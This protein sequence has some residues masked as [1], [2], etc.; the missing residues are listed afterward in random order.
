V[1]LRFPLQSFLL[2]VVLTTAAVEQ[3]TDG[4]ISGLV[5]DPTGGAI[6]GAEVLIVNDATGVKYVGAANGEGIYAVPNLPP[7]TYRIQVSKFGFK[8]LIKPDVVLSVQAA[9][10]INFTLPI[11]AVSETVTVQGGVTMV[12]ME[13]ASVST[14]IDRS[15]VE[16]MPLNG[17]SFQ[18]LI[19][20]TPGIVTNNPQNTP[21]ATGLGISGEFSVNG[22]RSESNYYIVDGVGANV[23]IYPGNVNE[24][25]TGGSL[26]AATALGTTQGL[27]SVDALQEF[28]VQSSTYSA[29]YGRS[30]GGQF[31]FVTRSGTNRWHGTAFDFLRNDLFDANDWFNGYYGKAKPSLRQN[32]FGGTVGGPVIVPGVYN[33]RNHTFFF[34]SY[35]GLR[36]DQPQAATLNYVPDAALRQSAPPALQ[37]V[38]NAFPVANGADVG[39]GLAEFT[40]TWSNPSQ[41]DATS[42]RFD[43]SVSDRLRLFFRF[44]STS[45]SAENRGTSDFSTPS[46][47]QSTAF[48]NH[49]YTLGATDLI[50]SRLSNDFRLNYSSNDSSTA[51]RI[52]SFG[53]GQAV[54]LTQLQ[55]LDQA[56]NPAY[57]VSV[58]L[59]FAGFGTA[60]NQ[61]RASGKQRQWNLVDSVNVTM[62]RHQFK[63]GADYRRL[64]PIQLSESPFALYY[65]FSAASAEANTI[66]FGLGETFAP[67]FPVYKNF[68]AFLQD[69]WRLSPKLTVSTGLRW[70][71]NPAPGAAKSGNL[72]YAT[73]GSS[74]SELSLASHGAPLWRTSWFNFAPRLGAAYVVRNAVGWET[75][76]RGGT[77]VFF[78]T[79]QQNAGAAWFNPGFS[80]T[81]FFSG[82]FPA[83]LEQVAPAIINPP[84]PPYETT[85][86]F[87]THFQLPYTL[88]W[89]VAVEQA[90]GRSQA[91][92]MSYVGA[93]GRRLLART[94]RH[95]APGHPNCTYVNFISNSLT[96]D[97]DALQLQFQRRLSG[98]LQALASYTWSHSIDSNSQNQSYGP[99]F[100]GNSDFDIRNN[101]SAALSYELPVTFRSPL[102]RAVLQHWG[103]DSRISARTGFP[104]TLFGNAF[105]DPTGQ[106]VYQGLN[107]VASHPVYLYGD[108]FPGGRSINPA[109]FMPVA[110]G[111]VGNAP[112]NFVNG[113]GAW[114][115]DVAIR[116]EFSIF[117]ALKLQLRVEAFNLFNHPNL[118]SIDSTYCAPGPGCRFGQATA[119][120]A[121]SLGVL[122]PLYQMGGSRSMQFALKL[123]F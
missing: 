54:D 41:I 120:L 85:Y 70:D 15:Y 49:T 14:V 2:L 78:D 37:P 123:M 69:E 55:G 94:E 26:P 9:V 117:E 28:R 97:Y 24:P 90:F 87:P 4:T 62:G 81:N 74:D 106:Y 59:S 36:L 52:T 30:P 86:A 32:D 83:P 107:M 79:G 68:S 17:R 108:Q 39:N 8:S 98:G 10:A 113:F 33:G 77:G 51:E 3:S 65:Y 66:D 82:T 19:L 38:L 100:R 44:A 101:L 114:Q 60:I 92:T 25:S 76:V 67:A 40:G 27:V 89:N 102:V 45:S 99:Y 43:Q 47:V 53:G 6:A 50:S 80:A 35:E 16:N 7:G 42:V 111:A 5:L 63:F 34:F 109:A 118:G 116:R 29:E 122:S 96:S 1:R 104:V 31:S 75:V 12:N 73:Q 20:L 23:G 22:Q 72:P 48:A 64:T 21:N 71:V 13:S 58:D 105:F 93:A 61:L 46:N 119:T 84:V 11:G 95:I 110:S 112:R 56:I 57:A 18:D 115:A 121:N 88:Q 91:L 103:L